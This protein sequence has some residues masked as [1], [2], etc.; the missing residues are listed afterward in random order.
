MNDNYENIDIRNTNTQDTD[1]SS[2]SGEYT[3]LTTIH[4]QDSTNEYATIGIV[5]QNQLNSTD[6][7]GTIISGKKVLE[8]PKPIKKS[9][10]EFCFHGLAILFASTFIL[11]CFAFTA[12][13]YYRLESLSLQL[14]TLNKRESNQ[15]KESS[16]I[17]KDLLQAQFKMYQNIEQLNI[18]SLNERDQ[19]EYYF[20]KISDLNE[21]QLKIFEYV[22]Q[23]NQSSINQKYQLD[24]YH[25]ENMKLNKTQLKILVNVE[26]LNSSAIEE[27]S[28]L[29]ELIQNLILLSTNA[30]NYVN[31]VLDN[32]G[33]YEKYPI[34][35]CQYINLIHPYWKSGYYWVKNQHGVAVRVY[36]VLSQSC[37][38]TYYHIRGC[39]TSWMRIAKLSRV[40]N[41][42]QCFTGLKN[43]PT[44]TSSCVTE[45]DSA[46]CSSTFF[47]SFN[48]PYSRIHGW[49]RAYGV[50][51]PD[52]FRSSSLTIND[53]YVDGIS[54]TVGNTTNRQH[55]HTFVPASGSCYR[56]SNKP[57]FVSYHYDCLPVL[58]IGSSQCSGYSCSESFYY[59]FETPTIDNIEMRVCRDQSRRD[60]DIVIEDLEIHVL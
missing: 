18:S 42:A 50:G 33:L 21:N 37:I 49:I 45:S 34:S 24:E 25:T 51:T 55:I 44:N 54:L 5:G 14:K 58:K 7:N 38:G 53:N 19:N 40:Q 20:N 23:V 17:I 41:R 3:E 22:E 11:L 10:K 31:D 39:T 2:R 6:T 46:T 52:G 9:R 28:Q 4:R 30:S 35:S 1:S 16:I 12:Y 56:C 48:I 13:N 60:E 36:C 26:Q 29:F 27:R 8:N 43:Y 15:L 57:T 59:T 47:S 32:I